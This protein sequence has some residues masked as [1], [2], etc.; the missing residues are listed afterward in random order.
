MYHLKHI[1]HGILL[2]FFCAL[3][4]SCAKNTPKR[5]APTARSPQ[6]VPQ[7][8][9]VNTATPVEKDD[10]TFS[11]LLTIAKVA[12]TAQ[13]HQKVITL[14]NESRAFDLNNWQQNELQ[15]LRINALLEQKQINLAEQSLQQFKPSSPEQSLTKKKL[16]L[17][18]LQHRKQHIA[19]L[20]LLF[21]LSETPSERKN[22]EIAQQIWQTLQQINTIALR[23]FSGKTNSANTAWI[24]LALLFRDYLGQPDALSRELGFWQSR[25]QNHIAMSVLPE[26]IQTAL[27]TTPY[28]PQKVAVLLPLSGKY[29]QQA[30]AIRN[31][32][33]TG[34]KHSE[35]ELTFINT[36][37][38]DEAFERLASLNPDFVIGP[39]QKDNISAYLAN[40]ALLNTPTLFLNAVEQP[41]E[42]AN[43]YYFDLSKNDEVEQLAKHIVD[44]GFRYPA[45]IAPDNKQGKRLSSYFVSAWMAYIQ[46]SPLSK[47]SSTDKP[48][49]VYFNNKATMQSAVKQLM[50][51]SSSDL[52]I[53]RMK[54][55][56][57]NQIKT[58]TRSRAD[59]DVIIL[60]ANPIQTRLLKPYIDVNTSTFSGEIPV[61]AT[62]KSHS[63]EGDKLDQKD[64]VSLKFTEIPWMLDRRRFK[65][66]R[67]LHDQLW[68]A[69]NDDAQRLFALGFDAWNLIGQLA[70][71]RALPSLNAQGM[72]GQLSVNSAGIV[73]R[74]FLWG[75]YNRN[76]VQQTTN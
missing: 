30:E 39:L 64:L 58:E 4:A 22:S 17:K 70:Q 2:L 19:A 15:A 3:L 12:E 7:Q 31:G 43:T 73:K 41:A 57:S 56:L 26:Q 11:Q 48:E 65:Q 28:A 10:T 47:A 76:G 32:I 16:T 5:S 66:Q 69:N 37:K 53:K 40:N 42:Q 25:Y 49:Q 67:A 9:E 13:Q 46:Q 71:M 61:Y 34:Y 45:I 18:I 62:S 21:D 20:M 60:I 23:T 72:T 44:Q 35:I 68:K 59:L 1:Y 52:R 14:V 8:A 51:V 75:I 54:R 74:K 29:Q 6:V 27:A 38:L 33:L 63:I 24:E 50:N 36:Q 55:L